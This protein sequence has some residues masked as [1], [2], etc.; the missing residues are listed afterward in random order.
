MKKKMMAM[1]AV[2]MF[3]CSN[4]FAEIKI[5]TE[6]SSIKYEEPGLMNEKGVMYGVMGSFETDTKVFLRADGR[7][8]WG[9]VDYHNFYIPS[10]FEPEGN[11]SGIDDFIGEARGLLGSSFASWLKLYTGIGYRYLSDDMEGLAT[12]NGSLGYL[13]ESNYVYLPIGA[14]LKKDF[15]NGWAIELNPEIDSLLWGKQ[16]SHL[17]A[18]PGFQKIENR[19]RKGYGVR[20]A[21]N[22]IREAGPAR[23]SVGPFVRYWR[24]KQSS[25]DNGFVEPENESTE[26]GVSAS[27]LF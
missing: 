7:A 11:I 10:S 22:V 21:V 15:K 14:R 2:A 3:V 18:I 16:I 5:G 8:A 27:V 25:A 12:E 26:F 23:I 17:D 13:R 4:L 9:K 20:M 24:I 1:I 6:I 19:Q